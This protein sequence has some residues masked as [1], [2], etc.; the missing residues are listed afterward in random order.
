MT[1]NSVPLSRVQALINEVTERL[2]KIVSQVEHALPGILH[3]T[4]FAAQRQHGILDL[5]FGW[6]LTK[7]AVA[8]VIAGATSAA[9]VEA[10]VAAA[11]WRL[12]AQDMAAVD[13]ITKR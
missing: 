1:T 12:S 11:S 9:Q 6:L 10:N 5:A 13:A 8:S 7:P 3:L 4:Q 2:D